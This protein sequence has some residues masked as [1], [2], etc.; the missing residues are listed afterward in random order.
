MFEP[1]QPVEPLR[2]QA[3]EVVTVNNPGAPSQLTGIAAC[4]EFFETGPPPPKPAK[5]TTEE[6]RERLRAEAI[7]KGET[8]FCCRRL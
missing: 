5:E 3:D 1:R 6:R 4:L 7:K 8:L 2:R